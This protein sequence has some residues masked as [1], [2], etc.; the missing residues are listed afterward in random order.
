V[1]RLSAGAIKVCL[2]Q[3]FQTGPANHPVSFCSLG[4]GCYFPRRVK[5]I[6]HKVDHSPPSSVQVKMSGVV[7]PLGSG[8]TI[9]YAFRTC[10]GT[11]LLLWNTHLTFGFLTIVSRKH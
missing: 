6:R 3:N 2:L 10:R 5:R 9:P 11:S 7:P 8:G 4:T 1:L